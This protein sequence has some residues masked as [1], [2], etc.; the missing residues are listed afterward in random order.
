MSQV[1]LLPKQDS[2]KPMPRIVFFPD[3][4]AE[5]VLLN[6]DNLDIIFKFNEAEPLLGASA[7]GCFVHVNALYNS[8]NSIF[9]K[10][11]LLPGFEVIDMLDVYRDQVTLYRST[12]YDMTSSYD[13]VVR[14]VETAG[15]KDINLPANY[16]RPTNNSMEDV[17]SDVQYYVPVLFSL[18][19]GIYGVRLVAV[20]DL[21]SEKQVAVA[22]LEL[23][24]KTF[25]T[26]TLASLD[27]FKR[28]IELC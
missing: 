19:D 18:R 20:T 3:A 15:M 22:N 1:D 11:E 9:L 12:D 4:L 16:I 25:P 17:E 5:S 10:S 2:L 6:L 8:R 21:Q 23:L 7:L 13:D 28:C 27:Y 24:S 26:S 14:Y